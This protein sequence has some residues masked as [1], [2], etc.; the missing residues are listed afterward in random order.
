MKFKL[1]ENLGKHV[2]KMFIHAGFDILSV[3]DQNLCGTNDTALINICKKEKRCIITLDLD[4]ANTLIFNPA[5]YSGIV[6]LRLPSRATRIDISDTAKILIGGLKQRNDI[7]G[8]LWVVKGERIREFL[9][10]RGV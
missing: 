8:K 10:N 6:V 9:I 3:R 2:K 4:F 5:N 7:E 1:D